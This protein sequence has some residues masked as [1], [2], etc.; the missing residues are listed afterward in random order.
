MWLDLLALSCKVKFGKL[1]RGKKNNSHN[2]SRSYINSLWSSSRSITSSPRLTQ[3]AVYDHVLVH[4]MTTQRIR[5]LQ[6]C[7]EKL[8][9]KWGIK[10]TDGLVNDKTMTEGCCKNI[11]MIWRECHH[12]W[13]MNL[14]F[15]TYEL[16]NIG[17][18]VISRSKVTWDQCV[19][20]TASRIWLLWLLRLDSL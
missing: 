16:K 1:R 3:G 17:Y 6:D 10:M 11:L 5:F 13:L 20:T 14:I 18:E 12:E 19:Q 9:F 15:S 2:A 7:T 4:H 8:S